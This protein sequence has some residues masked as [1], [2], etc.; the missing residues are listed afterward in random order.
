MRTSPARSILAGLIIGCSALALLG[1]CASTPRYTNPG[2]PEFGQDILN[3]DWDDCMRENT[4]ATRAKADKGAGAA[5]GPRVE[6][7][8]H[9]LQSCMAA[10]GWYPD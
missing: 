2:H 3:R 9:M 6:V 4:L 10:R 5:G 1:G 7:D 8:E